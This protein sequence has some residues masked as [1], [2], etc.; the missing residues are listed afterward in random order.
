MNKRLV[1]TILVLAAFILTGCEAPPDHPEQTS[2]SSAT[3]E[4]VIVN[5]PSRDIPFHFGY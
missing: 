5:P 1:A 3:S 2:D 4:P